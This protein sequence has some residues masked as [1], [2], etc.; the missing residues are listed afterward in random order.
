MEAQGRGGYLAAPPQGRE[1]T[2]TLVEQDGP[3]GPPEQPE[4]M[5]LMPTRTEVG[6]A[7]PQPRPRPTAAGGP[8]APQM[9]AA[10]RQAPVRAAAQ[11][12]DASET[13]T[14]HSRSPR[15]S[16]PHGP[17]RGMQRG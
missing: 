14:A 5:R 13:E 3:Y 4:G 7:E 8:R 17:S 2:S 15:R 10:V 9:A 1:E 11:A 6:F 12:G 16:L